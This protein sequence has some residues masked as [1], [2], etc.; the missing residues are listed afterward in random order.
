MCN[1]L[2]YSFK[3]LLRNGQKSYRVTFSAA[4]C[5]RKR[6]IWIVSRIQLL[7]MMRLSP[8]FT[9]EVINHRFLNRSLN[10]R[11][12]WTLPCT[13]LPTIW[14]KISK[15]IFYKLLASHCEFSWVSCVITFKASEQQDMWDLVAS[16]FGFWEL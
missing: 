2:W 5:T 11:W 3:P 6:T 10:D 13:R 14:R 15:N 12:H 8:E 9:P 7:W 4:L 16:Q 1:M